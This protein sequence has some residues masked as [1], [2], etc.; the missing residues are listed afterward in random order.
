MS[1][2]CIIQTTTDDEKV[3]SLISEILIEKNL[4]ACIQSYNIKSSYRWKGNI[5]NAT[6]ILLNIKTKSAYY[7][8]IE[9]VI[10]E[11]HNYEIPEIIVLPI[12]D[13]SGEYMEWIDKALNPA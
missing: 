12:I 2:Y 11:N 10:K 4:A 6:E 8:E 3:A 9:K 1:K 13:G 5:E 7:K